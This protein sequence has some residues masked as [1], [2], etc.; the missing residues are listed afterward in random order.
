M[1]RRPGLRDRIESLDA[2][3]TLPL[4][5]G[6]GRGPAQLVALGLAHSGD[7]VVWVGLCALAWF[8]GNAQWKM[9]AIIVFAGLVAAEVAVIGIKMCIRRP[10]PPGDAG[11]IY[12]KADP[13]SFPSGHAARAS[14][15]CLISIM[16]GPFAAALGIAVWS[17]FMIVSRIAI[18]IHYVFDV[19]AGI[20]LGVLLTLML[21]GLAPVLTSWI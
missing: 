14:M 5:L 12:R 2:S 21:L 8:L 20:V 17:P 1:T 9:R 3:L 6:P 15:L 11:R 13:F 7:S 16:L 4:T 18:G 19:I 10:R